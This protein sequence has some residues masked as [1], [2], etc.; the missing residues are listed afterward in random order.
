MLQ[1]KMV[2]LAEVM[3]GMALANDVTDAQG[4][5]L[6]GAGTALTER[7]LE[8]L[9]R[10]GVETVEVLARLELSEE[11]LTRRRA[12]IEAELEQR[13]RKVADQPLM[14][15]LRAL[16]LEHRMESMQ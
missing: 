8:Q 10:R 7:H 13:F 1:K 12:A 16:V 14:R 6:L 2:A 3:P 4:N 11:E 15:Q 5:R 9:A